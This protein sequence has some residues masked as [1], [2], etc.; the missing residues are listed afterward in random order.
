LPAPE[1][2]LPLGE[3]HLLRSSAEQ[4]GKQALAPGPFERHDPLEQRLDIGEEARFPLAHPNQAALARRDEGDTAR[5]LGA[6]HLVSDLVRDI[7][8]DEGGQDA[9]NGV[10]DLDA[11]HRSDQI[12]VFAPSE[13]RVVE[14][15]GPTG[16][17]E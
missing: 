8:N 9:R 5:P 1:A 14:S 6:R 12:V 7:E 11:R 3:R 2:E 4:H 10:G 15:R 13:P 16:G 17:L